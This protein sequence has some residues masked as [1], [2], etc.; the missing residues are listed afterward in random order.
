MSN[1]DSTATLQPLPSTASIRLETVEEKKSKAWWKRTEKTDAAAAGKDIDSSTGPGSGSGSGSD[2]ENEKKDKKKKEPPEPR[3]PYYKLYRFATPLDYL[4]IVLGILCAAANAA[5]MPL[6]AVIFADAMQSFISFAMNPSAPGAYEALDH[7]A[8]TN[9]LRFVGLGVALF[10]VAYGQS[11]FWNWSGENQAKRIRESY[12]QAV[13]RQDTAWHDTYPSGTLTTHMT[14]SLHLVQQG[15]SEKVGQIIQFVGTFFA[16]YIVA[17]TYSWRLALVMC[18]A[19]PVLAGAAVGMTKI[20]ADESGE[21]QDAYARAGGVAKQ[22]LGGIRTVVAFGGEERESRRYEG[23]LGLAEKSAIKKSLVNGAGVGVIDLAIY[24]VYALSFWFG[25]IEVKAGRAEAGDVVAVSFLIFIGAFSLG[26]GIPYINLLGQ[27]QGAAMKIFSTIDRVSPINGLD[28]TS[29]Q[30]PSSVSGTIEF[31]NV[32]FKYAT[33]EDVQVLESFDLKVE[34]GKTV[35]L[36]GMS[37]SGKST[38]VKLVERFYDPSVGNVKLDGVDL[39]DLNVG[40]LRRQ[41][42]MVQ[43]EPILFDA[44]VRQNILYGLKKPLST[45]SPQSLETMVESACKTAHAW[46]FICQLPRGLDTNVGEAGSMLSGGQKQRIAIARAIISNPKIL[47]L[48]EATSALDTTSERIVQRA[49]ETA[50]EGRTTIVIAH[51][52]STIRNADVVVVMDKGRVVEKGGH[53]ELVAKGGVYAELVKAQEVKGAGGAAD[54]AEEV[55][56]L[57]KEEKIDVKEVVEGHVVVEVE[58]KKEKRRSLVAGDEESE[59]EAEKKRKEELAKKKVDLWRIMKMNKP[60]WWLF[61]IGFIGAGL[62]GIWFPIFSLVFGRILAVFAETDLNEM[63][64]G[65][66]FWSLMFLL[67]GIFSFL[68]T[69]SNIAAF[70]VAGDKLTT[71]LRSVTF[72]KLVRMEIGFFDEEGHESGTLCARLGEDATLV[73]GLTGQSFGRI[74]QLLTTAVAGLVIAFVHSWRLTLVMFATVPLIAASGY[75]E[76]K[77]L[78]SSGSETKKAYNKT[79]QT[80]SEVIEHIRTVQSLN[81]EKAFLEKFQEGVK[82]PHAIAVKGYFVASLGYG[83]SAGVMF[84]AYAVSFYYGSRLLIWNLNDVE[85]ILIVMFA[86]IFTAMGAGQISTFA[87]DAAKARIATHSI[88][89]ILDRESRIDS[90]SPAGYV[91]ETA[92][93]SA[94]LATAELK[95]TQFAYPTRAEIP[96]LKGLSV[97]ASPGQT[98]ALVGASGCGKSTILGLLER[99]YDSTGGKVEVDGRDVKEWHLGS[100]RGQMALVG[101]EPV[102]FD[103]SVRENIAYGV[104]DVE[105]GDKERKE[106]DVSME[107]IREAARTANIHEFVEGLPDGYD[108]LVGE[109]GG[110]LSGGQKQR[111]AIARALIRKPR[112]LLLDEATS[113]LDSESEGVV[114][115][116]LDNASKGRTTVTIAHRLS[117]IQAAQRICVV[118]SG[119]VVEWGSHGELMEKRGE[120]WELARLQVLGKQ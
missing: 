5:G 72:R 28:D 70:R 51:R 97:L 1:T 96:V 84:W 102:L 91:P 2:S 11:C 3:V 68:T 57:E 66:N 65:A 9:S 26:Q 106:R 41:I 31:E 37:G 104:V 34:S 86:V 74:V 120:Y 38:I 90:T 35:A 13:L 39:R 113:A 69:F 94:A 112:I 47:L 108:T 114:Q 98:L 30:S 101:Q 8:R 103:M 61:V 58:K 89:D 76:M 85:D 46:S 92:F 20:I 23:F 32:G 78:T 87:P 52:L 64:N 73:Q 55:E 79:A 93:D 62:S 116:A 105:G 25:A 48:D 109:K 117:S 29:G 6:M 60:E 22:V 40:W 42:G 54:K 18:S 21:G 99:W 115:A 49:L 45:Y 36:V 75:F 80:A 100:L 44:T 82:G 12:F 56:A 71:R 14:S 27:G 107:E 95:E 19:F 4:L 17:F 111:I 24:G 15:I 59:D 88:L 81:Q 33:R 7:D 110:R 50:S 63:Q 83:M 53:E 118:K 43:Q 67:L 119:E 16:C 77:S 10:L